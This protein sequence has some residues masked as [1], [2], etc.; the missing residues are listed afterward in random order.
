MIHFV[1]QKSLS[2][3]GRLSLR[4]R[5]GEGLLA[6]VSVSLVVG[7]AYAIW[8]EPQ[9]LVAED[10]VFR[11]SVIVSSQ[12][13]GPFF[14]QYASIHWLGI[15]HPPL[16]PLLN[17]FAMRFAGESLFVIRLVSV[18]FGVG[19]VVVLYYLGCELYGRLLGLV[20]SIFFVSFPYFFRLS[21]S[22]SNDIQVCF[23]TLLTL[24]VVFRICRAP[25]FGLSVFAGI[26][27][28][29]GI[30]SKYPAL[31]L[32]PILFLVLVEQKCKLVRAHIA[33]LMTTSLLI[34]GVWL[35]Y[36]SHI[37]VFALQSSTILEFAGSQVHAVWGKQMLLEFC[38]TRLPSAVGVYTL[39]A[40]VLG[41][42]L[43]F[44][45]LGRSTN[46]FILSWVAVFFVVFSLTLPDARYCL[47][48]FPALAILAAIGLLRM[49]TGKDRLMLLILANC[50]GSLY[51][52]YD[53]HRAQHVFIEEVKGLMY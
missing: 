45:E 30:L 35:V 19:S 33:T 21:A 52:F 5:S 12:G 37:G 48:A 46:R 10:G 32:F 27:L 18:F 17:G 22:A 7:T 13:V 9:A 41:G 23:F 51:L 44:R 39:P 50:A 25:S 28:S 14:E 49:P 47:P 34:V 16:V 43:V 42:I 20:G 38:F 26:T 6:L 31:L 2:L 24:L 4:N 3:F 29:M 8:Q 53:W 40:M 15:Q 36:A 1:P 11:A